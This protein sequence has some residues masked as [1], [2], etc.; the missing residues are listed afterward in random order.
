MIVVDT[1]IIVASLIKQDK[2]DDVFNLIELDPEWC[3][4][5]LWRSELRSALVMYIKH[6]DVSVRTAVKLFEHA[7]QYISDYETDVSSKKVFE[8]SQKSSCSAYDCEYVALAQDLRVSLVTLD[9]KIL[10]AFP[11][12]SFTPQQYINSSN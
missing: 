7:E 12:I 9:K 8:L 11:K 3:C 1:N 4:P 5:I 6:K 2:T 10:R